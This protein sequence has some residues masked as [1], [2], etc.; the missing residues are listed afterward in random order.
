MSPKRFVNQHTIATPKTEINNNDGS[1][2]AK[3]IAKTAT[4]ST[5]NIIG[6]VISGI[7]LITT[8]ILMNNK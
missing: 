1:K 3:T 6:L 2:F 5:D 7:G 8:F 4:A